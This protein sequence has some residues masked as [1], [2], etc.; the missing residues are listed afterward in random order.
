MRLLVAT[1][2]RGK[3]A[4]I[5][6]L[7]NL[8]GLE[9]VTPLEAGLPADFDVEETGTTFEENAVLKAVQYAQAAHLPA[10]ADDSGLEVDALDGQPGVYSKRFAGED[11]TDQYRIDFLLS[12]L[13]PDLPEGQLTARFVAAVAFANPAGAIL[14][15][16]QGFCEGHITRHQRGTNGFGYDPIFVVNAVNRTL[17]ELS[18]AEKD[19]YSHR[20]DAV[21]RIRPFIEQYAKSQS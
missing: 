5:R 16:E 12:K 13:P 21:T 11:K 3:L 18:A 17:A 4:E 20:G 6:T 7:L 19:L 9:L 2:N 8:P 15:I 14:K 10:L 1:N